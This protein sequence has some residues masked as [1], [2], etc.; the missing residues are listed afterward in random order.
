MKPNFARALYYSYMIQLV[1]TYASVRYH[2]SV[3][4]I[5][6]LLLTN[7]LLKTLNTELYH[8]L[9]LNNKVKYDQEQD[10]S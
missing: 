3:L 4:L 9:K 2:L 7:K 8:C 1:L 6:A 10:T 5:Q